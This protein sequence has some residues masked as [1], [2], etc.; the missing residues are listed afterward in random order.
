MKKKIILLTLSIATLLTIGSCKKE[1]KDPT[2][3]IAGQ[4]GTVAKYWKNGTPNLLANFADAYGIVVSGSDVYVSGYIDDRAVYWK[5]G[6][7]F[8]LSDGSRQ[9][10]SNSIAVADG[11]VYASGT[12]GLYRCYWKNGIKIILYDGNPTSDYDSYAK[13]VTLLGNDILVA[14]YINTTGDVLYWKN[15]TAVNLEN[16]KGYNI[17]TSSILTTSAG[18]IYVSGY[19]S[20]V[21]AP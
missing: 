17:G 2:V 12:D 8:E 18:D 16:G 14:G 21:L 5:N 20:L 11:T 1:K 19:V 6:N 9:A 7:A 10:Y 15:A 3:Y 4:E 13:G